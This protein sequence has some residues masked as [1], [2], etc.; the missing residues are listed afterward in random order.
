VSLTSGTML[1]PYEILGPLGAGGMGEVYRARDTR[2]DRSVAVKVIPQHLSASPE[3][4]QRFEREARA[5]SA[6]NHPHICT[7]HDVGH[8][9]GTDY[10]VME[11]ID[12]ETLA[13]RLEKGPLP[14]ELLLR[15]AIEIASA[16]DRAH[17]SG[18]VHRDLKPGN[19]MLTRSGAKLLDFGLAQGNPTAGGSGRSSGAIPGSL[20]QTPTMAQPLTA[21]G[22][23]IGT[24]QYMAPEQLEGKEA[25][26][27]TDL[28][29][30]GAVLYE[31]ATGRK[32]FE[33][34]SQASLISAI[35]SSEPTPLS[36]VAPLAPPTLERIVRAC[37]AK[38]ADER[39][40]TAHDVKLQL[41]WIRD[42][43]SQAGVPAPVAARRK[44]RERLA[45][46]LGMLVVV[47]AAA[48]VVAMPWLRPRA[49]T[50]GVSRFSI[51]APENVTFSSDAAF[52]AI[53]P[54]GRTLA[55]VATDSSGTSQ[56]WVRPLESLAPRPLAGTENATLPF[57]S[58]DGS[59]L[60]FFADGKLKKVPIAGGSPEAICD[61]GDGRG[62]SWS[63]DGVIVFAPQASG[64]LF[65]VS[66]GGGEVTQATSLDSSRHEIGHR[67][68]RFLPDAKHFL[69][70]GMPARQ[71]NFDIFVGVLGSKDG[72]RLLSAS[73]EPTYA[74]PGYLIFVR[75]TSLFAQRFDP[76]RLV[77]KGEPISLGEAPPPSSY[78][79]AGTV[80]ASVNGIMA[81][82]GVGLPNTE[83]RW[84]D[85]AGNPSGTI[86]VPAG[87][88]EGVVLSPDGKRLC[89]VRRSGASS[90]DLWL[91]DL[92]RPVP[93]RFTFGP[94][95]NYTPAWSPDGG[96]IAFAADRSGPDD[97][98]LKPTSGGGAEAPLLVGGALFKEP[99]SWS[100]DG[101]YIVFEQ[102]DEQ[103]GWD[104][105]LLPVDGDHTPVAYLRTP[106]N[107]RYAVVSPDGRWIA[108]NSDESG[109]SEVY[110]QSFPSPGSKYQ[111]STNGS[112]GGSTSIEWTRGGDELVFIGGDGLTLM[113]ADVTS[114]PGFRVG[115]P[116]KLFKARQDL[117]AWNVTPD[118]QRFLIVAPAGLASS[119]KITLEMNWTAALKR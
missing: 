32:A 35:M 21:E 112:S 110:V 22:T 49:S 100:P 87:R 113:A 95:Q 119:S 104:L 83:L 18:I 36:T 109:K 96:R 52:S 17:R 55:F 7:L 80:T 117:V 108:Y 72:K 28:F 5:I 25:D 75:N 84:V 63:R 106:F 34:K 115:A 107:E 56:I 89:V 58:P 105:W 3:M 88:Y 67:W 2:L 40:Q 42:A 4:R 60:G 51:A 64:P 9:D 45:W 44:S 59:Q 23:I 92:D 98:Y 81:H 79:G 15:T 48:A 39:I 78:T 54:D 85:R 57:W 66:V 38:E 61:A 12:G 73:S 91:L 82:M 11:L 116:R 37:L 6:L 16:L 26:A 20:T 30:F 29:A 19:V 74:A 68:P 62:A 69:F 118:G 33:G 13:T 101:R 111:V 93:T 65:R 76:Q 14:T 24:Y 41:E 50:E 77:L 43:G 97:I 86:P 53:S 94:S 103:T 90:E 27:R 70:V 99:D 31:M 71:G 47:L 1:G 102:P 114:S 8:Q 10:L 46:S